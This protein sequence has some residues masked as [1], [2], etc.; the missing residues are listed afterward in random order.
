MRKVSD[1]FVEC[2]EAEGVRWVF[3]IPGEETL[4]LNESLSRSS[5]EFVPVRHEQ[6]GAFM[7]GVYGRLTGRAGVCLGTLGPGATNLATGVADAFLDRAPLV[8]LT[9]Q[10]GQERMHKESHQHIDV[11]RLMQP[12]TKWN[13]RLSDPVIAPEVVRKAFKLAEADKPGAT[14]VELPEGVM[15]SELDAAPL[16]RHPTG[17]P[18]ARPDDIS[19][20]ARLI[21]RA[22]SPIALAGNGVVRGQAA[23]A[24]RDFAH[25]TGLRV[26]KTFM[27]KGLLD[28]Y[29][30]QSLGAV[31]LQAGDYDMAGFGKADVVVTIGYDLVEHA[32]AHWNPDRDKRIVCVDSLPAEIDDAFIPEVELVGDLADSLRRLSEEVGR[33]SYPGGSTRLREVTIGR[34]DR[35]GEDPDTPLQPPRV[36][37]EL[38]QALGRHDILVSD[39]GL[40]KL[41]IGRMFPA[42]EPQSVLIANGLAGMGFAVPA[43]VA[44]KLVRPECRVVA[45][46][47][48][49]GFLMNAAEL[50]TAVRLR[51]PFVNVV[52]EDHAYGSIIRHQ[53]QKFGRH[54]GTG[55]GNPDFVGLAEA[56]GLPAWRC[57]SAGEF[58]ARLVEALKLDLPSLIVLPIDYSVDVAIAEELG[59]GTAAT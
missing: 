34:F 54:F 48:D 40:H 38:R 55:F 22:T 29:D 30:D 51:T 56:F 6:A 45:V 14:H 37:W 8:A 35:A 50:E 2:L 17:R 58:S 32:P 11:V 16:P 52:W 59:P 41:W 27:G 23:E 43:A 28:T 9:G 25:S 7:A 21:S 33:L 47:G 24:L 53:E 57:E 20:A 19:R 46:S 18:Q 10:A 3:G 15:E 39:V 36:L 1:V 5:I 26:A 13:A 31:G 49:G 44:A 4:D 42:L 12:I